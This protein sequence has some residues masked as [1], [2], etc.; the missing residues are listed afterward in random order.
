MRFADPG[1]CS[2]WQSRSPS[3]SGCSGAG[4]RRRR[5]RIGFPALGFLTDAPTTPAG[6]AGAGCPMRFGSS[7]LALLIVALARPQ[8]PHDVRQIRSKARNIMVALDISSSM[9]AG[10][11]KPGNRLEVARAS[12]GRLRP[13]APGRSHR[14]GDLRR[15]LLPPGPAHPRYRSA[16]PDARAGG[17]RAC[18]PMAPRSER[19]SR[20]PQPAQGPAAEGQRRS[21]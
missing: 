14:P 7:A 11:F 4:L 3:A 6:D 2:S 19:R 8:L 5:S 1:C 15:P 10:D 21:C 12:A 9:K 20:W 13:P 16:G 18:C 17:Y